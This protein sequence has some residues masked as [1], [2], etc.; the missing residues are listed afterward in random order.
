MK[1]KFYP[2]VFVA[3]LVILNVFLFYRVIDFEVKYD[4]LNKAVH[5][6][7]ENKKP[8]DNTILFDK[9][10][11]ESYIRQQ[12]RDTTLILTVFAL[13]AGF[14]AFLTFRSFATKVEEHAA[15]ID[16]KYADHETKNQEHHKRVSKLEDDLNYEASVLKWNEA[17]KF[18]QADSIHYF[19]FYAINS[20]VMVAKCVNFNTLERPNYGEKLLNAVISNLRLI[21][22][23]VSGVYM[24]DVDKDF[25]IG[26]ISIINSVDNSEVFELLNSIYSQL[27]FKE[28][29]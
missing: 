9:F 29:S 18:Y 25:I 10:K 27:S 1:T 11:E 13:F 19:V 22:S 8:N 28:T 7:I 17:E 14:T 5:R 26:Q 24:E 20:T 6:I 4:V 3:L 21:K 12:E 23:R 16:K 2:I 15:L